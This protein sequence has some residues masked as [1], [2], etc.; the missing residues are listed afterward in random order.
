[1]EEVGELPTRTRPPSVPLPSRGESGKTV[2]AW[3][4]TNNHEVRGHH[5]DLCPPDRRHSQRDTSYP[6]VTLSS[7]WPSLP[8]AGDPLPLNVT[9]SRH[10]PSIYHSERPS[11]FVTMSAQIVAGNSGCPAGPTPDVD[12]RIV[13]QRLRRASLVIDSGSLIVDNPATDSAPAGLMTSGA[14]SGPSATILLLRV[15]VG[16]R[17][18]ERADRGGCP[19]ESVTLMVTLS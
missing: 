15:F 7:V 12:S 2:R 8:R 1:M 11:A 9:S 18:S 10:Q 17:R 6:L 4:A 16:L 14:P 5:S 3:S 19:A 13:D